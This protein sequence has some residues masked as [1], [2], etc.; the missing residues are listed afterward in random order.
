MGPWLSARKKVEP[1]ER[2][3]LNERTEAILYDTPAARDRRSL[4]TGGLQ[5]CL[6]ADDYTLCIELE[7]KRRSLDLT[8]DLTIGPSLNKIVGCCHNRFQTLSRG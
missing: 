1:K 4:Y 5:H 6:A 3:Q 2:T 8:L 7:E